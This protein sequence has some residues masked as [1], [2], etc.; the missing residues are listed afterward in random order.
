MTCK[1]FVAADVLD[2][3]VERLLSLGSKLILFLVSLI[4]L[5]LHFQ[6]CEIFDFARF[7][8]I[9]IQQLFR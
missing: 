3:E 6:A 9:T 5:F 2:S 4:V 8:E 1:V 7:Q